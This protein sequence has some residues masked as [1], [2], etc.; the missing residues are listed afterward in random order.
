MRYSSAPASLPLTTYHQA[1]VTPLAPAHD[2][3]KINKIEPNLENNEDPELTAWASICSELGW[4]GDC[5]KQLSRAIKQRGREY[6]AKAIEYCKDKGGGLLR[7][8]LFKGL[9]RFPESDRNS[10]GDHPQDKQATP[11]ECDRSAIGE[12]PADPLPAIFHL[13]KRRDFTPARHALLSL[14]VTLDSAV[15]IVSKWAVIDSVGE[16]RAMLAG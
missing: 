2:I 7:W 9:I 1:P 16:L 12:H 4:Y 11:L 10:T 8:G 13:L 5:V 6:V 15:K 3:Y 14:G